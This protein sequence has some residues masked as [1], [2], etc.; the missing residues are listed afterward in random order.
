MR[1][2]D[3]FIL[4]STEQEGFCMALVEAMAMGIPAIS[5]NVGIA[6]EVISDGETGWLVPARDTNALTE[7]LNQ[8]LSLP[9]GAAAAVGAAG[10]RQ[11]LER[12]S[13][14]EYVRQLD[15]LYDVV[16]RENRAQVRA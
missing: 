9:R 3:Y 12:G 2:C 7:K 13:P 1:A 8:V 5:T 15:A 11:V 6:P 4:P 16:W 14:T 10:R